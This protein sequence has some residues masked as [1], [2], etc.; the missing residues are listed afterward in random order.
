MD[1]ELVAAGVTSGEA[2]HSIPVLFT[3]PFGAMLLSIAVLPLAAP[4]FWESNRNK[5]LVALGWGLPVAALLVFRFGAHGMEWLVHSLEEYAAFITLLAALFVISGGVYLRGSLAGT[6]LTNT[7][8]LAIGALLASFVGTTGASMLLIRPLLRANGPRQRKAHIVIFFIFI[9][10]NGGGMLTPLGDPPLFLGFLRGVPFLWTFRLFLPWAMVNALLLILFNLVDQKVLD[11]EEKERPGSQL[12]EVQKVKEP[13]RIQGRRNFVYL[14]GVIA[15]IFLMGTYG[16][17]FLPDPRLQLAA[18]VA[19]MLAM[20]V[21]SLVTTPKA[22]RAAN[23]FT[24]HPIIEVAYLFLG[25]FLTMIPALRLLESKGGALGIDS[26]WQFFWA[27]GLL[28]SFLDNAPTYLTF[29][30]LAVGVVNGIHAGAGLTADFLGGLLR[31]PEGVRFLTAISCGAVF[32]GANSYI[33]NGPNFMVKSI[34]EE[35]GV[36]MPSFFGYMAWSG[37]ILI[38]IFAVV[39]LV[40]FR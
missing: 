40:F 1:A 17:R 22:Y 27:S 21:L 29:A 11:R 3:L 34:A 30:S 6:P 35:N 19:G 8:F 14:L 20:G 36:R 24:W 9:V 38:P 2:L 12:E 37:A 13:L 28:S 26:P 25:I 7:G 32:M 4:H 18:Q 39:T 33:G 5:L 10:A 23:R 31:Y 16:H 15:V